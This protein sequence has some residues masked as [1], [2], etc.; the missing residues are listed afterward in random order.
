MATIA[1]LLCSASASAFVVP[2]GRPNVAR[3]TGASAAKRATLA[4]S[5]LAMS[6]VASPPTL[7]PAATQEKPNVQALGS[8]D[9]YLAAMAQNQ[10]KLVVVKFF[11]QF[12]RACD[13]I[14]PRFEEMS[15]SQSSED[16]AFFELE[17]STSKDLCKQLGIKRLPTVQIYDGSNG[18]VSDLP[19]GPS[20]F[21][22][23]EERFE[24]LSSAKASE[25][26]TAE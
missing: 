3:Q 11:D 9:E 7:I 18:R 17:F 21:A 8:H 4:R 6:S 25:K 12:C 14:R 16:A 23:I 20:R 15:R 5:G 22:Q 2:A 1:A 26:A 24:E 10:D 19:A 13:E